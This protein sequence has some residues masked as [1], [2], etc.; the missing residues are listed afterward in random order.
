MTDLPAVVS[1]GYSRTWT[2]ERSLSRLAECNG[3]ADHDCFLFLDAPSCE[4]DCEKCNQ[5][6]LLANRV[7]KTS[8]PNLTIIRRDYNLGV[9]G[10]LITAVN[11]I[12]MRYNKIIFFEDDVCVSRTFLQF[13][14][15]A[16]DFYYDD[17]RIFCIN[18][19]KSP[20]V[21]VPRSYDKDV[22]LSPRNMAWGFGIWRDRWASVDFDLKDWLKIKHDVAMLARLDRAG[23]DLINLINAQSEGRIHTWDIQCTYHMVKNGLYAIEPKLSLTKNIGFGVDGVHCKGDNPVFSHMKYYDFKPLLE[24]GL[25][26]NSTILS[27]VRTLCLHSGFLQRIKRIIH[28]MCVRLTSENKLPISLSLKI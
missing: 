23:V 24:R 16:L 3:V 9:P 27:E 13:M 21:R 8:I 14:D 2:L 28:R 10:N 17:K 22:Y 7:K 11:E 18:G 25:P 20:Y 12:F 19:F 5:M 15:D 6:F 4:A 1:I 26:P